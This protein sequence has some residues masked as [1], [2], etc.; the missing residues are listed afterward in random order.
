MCFNCIYLWLV[1]DH[2]CIA[3][4]WRS[5]DNLKEPVLSFNYVAL[6]NSLG[7]NY[8][9]IFLMSHSVAEVDLEFIL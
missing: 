1:R 7:S 4:L 8:K 3:L 6:V 9:L 5:E 2:F